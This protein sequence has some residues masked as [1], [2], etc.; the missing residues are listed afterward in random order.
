MRCTWADAAKMMTP[1]LSDCISNSQVSISLWSLTLLSQTADWKLSLTSLLS[2]VIQI[3]CSGSSVERSHFWRDCPAKTYIVHVPSLFGTLKTLTSLY[4][5]NNKTQWNMLNITINLKGLTVSVD[6][7]VDMGPNISDDILR[8]I[9][10]NQPLG[11]F[12]D[13]QQR[14]CLPLLNCGC[15]RTTVQVVVAKIQPK[16]STLVRLSH[17]C[18]CK[19]TDCSIVTPSWATTGQ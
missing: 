16:P 1:S 8:L 9:P 17:S 4:R 19:S 12:K 7:S 14:L 15:T 3:S 2:S 11:V 13:L 5:K 10:P 6:C 18:P